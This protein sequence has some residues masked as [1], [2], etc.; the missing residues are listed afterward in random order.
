MGVITHRNNLTGK[1]PVLL[2]ALA[3]LAVRPGIA[4]EQN[5]EQIRR[6]AEQGDAQAQYNLGMRYG[7][8]EEPPRPARRL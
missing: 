5:I 7:E 3:I 4:E 2:V 6:S 8:S 1:L